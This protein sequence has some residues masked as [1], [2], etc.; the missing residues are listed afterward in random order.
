MRE[1]RNNRLLDISLG[2]TRAGWGEEG[3]KSLAEIS[4]PHGMEVPSAG[5][6]TVTTRKVYASR[7]RRPSF[8]HLVHKSIGDQTVE[9]VL[10]KQDLLRNNLFSLSS[11]THPPSLPIMCA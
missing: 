5:V 9:K 11:N 6:L 2:V 8:R 4:L 1:T 7:K 3:Y 10:T